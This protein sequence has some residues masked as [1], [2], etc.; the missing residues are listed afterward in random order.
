M[1][2]MFEH[3]SHANTIGSPHYS[4]TPELR[5]Y[6]NSFNAMPCNDKY[7]NTLSDAPMDQKMETLIHA[8]Q[9]VN[10]GPGLSTK[11]I[12]RYDLIHDHTQE[13]IQDPCQNRASTNIERR[14]YSGLHKSN[15]PS[16]TNCIAGHNPRPPNRST[17]DR[18]NA[19]MRAAHSMNEKDYLTAKT[20]T[21]HGHVDAHT[22]SII[23][24]P[25]QHKA[26]KHTKRR[27]YCRKCGSSSHIRS[28][29]NICPKHPLYGQNTKKI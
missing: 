29:K 11:T 25:G 12:T 18:M 13:T 14:A 10:E 26:I 23:Q 19:L 8:T 15:T 22:Q 20:D 7:S 6:T 17:D 2:S 3:D 21:I 1:F 16:T 9:F 5:A 24:P 28:G 27:A 4:R